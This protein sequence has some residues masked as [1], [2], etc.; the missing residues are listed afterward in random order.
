MSES[1]H[2]EWKEFWRDDYIKWICGFANAEGGVLVIGRDDQGSDVGISVYKDRVLFWNPC[3]L[4]DNWTV[5]KLTKKHPSR[6][7]NPDI[8]NAFFRAGLL[9][10]W[11]RGTL[12]IIS[13]CQDA[14]L[15]DPV[16]EYDSPDFTLKI[17]GP[18]GETPGK[19]PDQI[20]ALLLQDA[21]LTIPEIAAYL[22]KD[23]RTI[24]RAI[25]KL[26]DEGRLERVG[27]AKGGYWKVL[28]E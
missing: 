4:P 10:S 18:L 22:E 23:V 20:L 1:Q 11:G 28:E 17:F 14:G 12:K 13:E 26:R 2:M 6:P 21:H 9:E 7:F 5:D 15:P 3:Q 16:Y 19:T 8:A 27:P 24:E 25:S